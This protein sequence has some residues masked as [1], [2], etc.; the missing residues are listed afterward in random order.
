MSMSSI[1]QQQLRCT[2]VAACAA[3]SRHACR[4]ASRRCAADNVQGRLW[5]T[6]C[7]AP[8]AW[9]GLARRSTGSTSSS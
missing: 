7:T 5:M 3:V 8:A 6:S 4:T 9:L 1:A 2:E